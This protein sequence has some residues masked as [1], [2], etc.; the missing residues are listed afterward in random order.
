M[1]HFIVASACPLLGVDGLDFLGDPDAADGAE[2]ELLRAGHAAAA[3][4]AGDKSCVHFATETH[5]SKSETTPR[6]TGGIGQGGCVSVR[7]L[8]PPALSCAS[9]WTID[10]ASSQPDEAHALVHVAT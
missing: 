1:F 4:S 6:R 7:P 2:P 9:R 10:P 5:L 8:P 3:V